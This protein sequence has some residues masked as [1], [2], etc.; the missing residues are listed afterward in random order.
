MAAG[1]QLEHIM[2]PET[3]SYNDMYAKALSGEITQDVWFEY[4]FRILSQIMGE[5]KDVFIRLKNR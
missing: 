3:T 5:N 4:C 2:N 1:N